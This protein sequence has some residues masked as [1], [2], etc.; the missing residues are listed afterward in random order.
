[1]RAGRCILVVLAISLGGGSAAAADKPNLLVV[2]TDDQGAWSLGC[3]G[4]R[5]ARTPVVDRLA[6]DGVRLTHAFAFTPVCSPSRAT[7]FT[8]RIPSQHG[9]HDWIKHENIGNRARYCLE[10]EALL[11]DILSRSGYSCGL[12]GKWHLGDTMRPHPGFSYW[13][14]L[15]EGS[16]RYQD[17][18]AILNGE[19]IQTEGYLTDGI[20]DHAL[21]FLDRIDHRPFYLEVQ[22]NAPHSPWIGHDPAL[23]AMFDDCPFDSIPKVDVHPWASVQM[24][25]IG[26]RA[27]LQQYFA[28]C[29]GVDRGV[30]RILEK[31]ETLGVMNDTLVVFTSDQ[32]FCCGHRG[33]WGKGNAS[34]P[35]NMF[36]P[37]MRTPMIFRWPGRIEGGRE[38]DAMVSAIDFVPT[39]LA[40]LELPPSPAR[41]LPGRSFAPLL[42][43]GEVAGWPDAVFG[44]YGRARM[45]RTRGH[46][47]VHRADGGPHELYDLAR[48]PEET[49]NL[50]DSAD[51]L[52]LRRLLRDR[53]FTWFERYVEAGAD[54]VGQEY[55]HPDD[56]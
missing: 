29:A 1:M 13:F 50:A 28:A 45:I 23:V 44:E 35:R 14:T 24:N 17:A 34:N 21:A 53:L 2:M 33:L 56:R 19:R 42:S 22:Y 32:G 10:G 43:G 30:G 51:H 38:L 47:Y 31:L 3:Y 6:A 46:K 16:S 39:L 52:E 41:H 4:N 15:L 54:P 27:T 20:T 25:Q 11:A 7:F 9:I 40:L 8:G 36:D 55:L 48:D 5:E 12:S 37:S 26:N 18:E 49:T